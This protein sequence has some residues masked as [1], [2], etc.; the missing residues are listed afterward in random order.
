LFIHIESKTVY[1]PSFLATLNHRN[2]IARASLGDSV[3]KQTSL[4]KSLDKQTK[5]EFRAQTTY[6]A[7]TVKGHRKRPRPFAR[8]KWNHIVFKSDLKR[9]GLSFLSGNNRIELTRLIR[10]KAEK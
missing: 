10:A 6:G 8:Q 7:S 3:T 4:F 5:K 1:I 2:Y 9:H